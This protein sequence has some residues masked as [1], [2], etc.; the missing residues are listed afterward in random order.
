MDRQRVF[1]C[2]IIDG[3]KY[4]VVAKSSVKGGLIGKYFQFGSE[5]SLSLIWLYTYIHPQK[6][7]K[8]MPSPSADP[9]FSLSILKFLSKLKLLKSTKNVSSILK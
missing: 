7:C 1:P 3:S 6:K 9:K 2:D 8:I 4:F 5:T